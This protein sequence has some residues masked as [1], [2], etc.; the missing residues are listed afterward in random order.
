MT[1]Q[2]NSFITAFYQK[3]M[4]HLISGW[5]LEYMFFRQGSV[6]Y[7]LLLYWQIA[8]NSVFP[9]R[10]YNY[11]MIFHNIVSLQWQGKLYI[12]DNER[13]SW[14][15]ATV[16]FSVSDFN[17]GSCILFREGMICDI[18]LTWFLNHVCLLSV[19]SRC[20]QLCIVPLILSKLLDY[21]FAESQN[22]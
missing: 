21:F 1:G 4:M 16:D 22:S 13:M 12:N 9:R 19:H 18:S 11:F 15:N 2:N 20:L 8:V 6:V 7:L 17:T 10:D 14:M 5:D 3:R